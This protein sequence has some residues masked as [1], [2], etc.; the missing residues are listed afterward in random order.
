MLLA[1]EV[2]ATRAF[3]C[4]LTLGATDKTPIAPINANQRVCDLRIIDIFGLSESRMAAPYHR[5]LTAVEN[6]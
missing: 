3:I 4:A 6:N 5:T 2:H 1:K